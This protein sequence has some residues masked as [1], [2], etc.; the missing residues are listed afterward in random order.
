MCVGAVREPPLRHGL[1]AMEM[2]VYA[3]QTKRHDGFAISFKK[4]KGRQKP[5]LNLFQTIP[6]NR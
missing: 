5:A 2:A 4:R 1:H 3:S 6:I